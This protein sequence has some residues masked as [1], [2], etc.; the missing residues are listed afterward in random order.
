M[1]LDKY[2][3]RSFKHVPAGFCKYVRKTVNMIRCTFNPALPNLNMINY[4]MNILRST[5]GMLGM[6]FC[7]E[8]HTRILN[9]PTVVFCSQVFT[10]DGLKRDRNSLFLSAQ[11]DEDRFSQTRLQKA[12]LHLLMVK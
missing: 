2:G 5:T 4:T 7:T 11:T 1:F 3:Y 9:Q 10:S 12:F 6:S 8:S